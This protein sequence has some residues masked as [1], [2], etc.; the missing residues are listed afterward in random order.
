MQYKILALPCLAVMIAFVSTTPSTETAIGW[1]DGPAPP[2]DYEKRSEESL[3]LLK[4][5][6][7]GCPFDKYQCN[8]HVSTFRPLHSESLANLIL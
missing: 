8:S 4:A 7:F 5:R 6:G 3:N 1:V 2:A